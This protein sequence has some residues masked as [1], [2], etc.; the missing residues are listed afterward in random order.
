MEETPVILCFDVSFFVLGV[1]ST[2]NDLIMTI[3]YLI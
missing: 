1:A 3:L 2:P